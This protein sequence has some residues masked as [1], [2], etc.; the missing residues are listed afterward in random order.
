MHLHSAQFSF[1]LDFFTAARSTCV[2]GRGLYFRRTRYGGN[3]VYAKDVLGI[4]STNCSE[5]SIMQSSFPR[6][7][8]RSFSTMMISVRSVGQLR[9]KM[10]IPSFADPSS[11]FEQL[12]IC[13]SDDRRSMD[14]SPPPRLARRT[15]VRRYRVV[16]QWI[17]ACA[18]LCDR[19]AISGCR[20]NSVWPDA[21]IDL[22]SFHWHNAV[23][24]EFH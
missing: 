16:V 5:S 6:L 8:F 24:L 12:R 18:A 14:V 17:A 4:R 3:S 7:E 2:D 15:L 10:W 11:D 1:S 23:H 21:S 20:V 13:N 9:R 22:S 19:N